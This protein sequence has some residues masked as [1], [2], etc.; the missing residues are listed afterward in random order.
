[1]SHNRGKGNPVRGTRGLQKMIS[2]SLFLFIPWPLGFRAFNFGLLRE[3]DRA[4]GSIFKQNKNKTKKKK[5]RRSKASS[6]SSSSFLLLF[7]GLS[8]SEVCVC[9]CVRRCGKEDWLR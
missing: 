2:H 8:E 6:S 4:K 9:V 5:K 7:L 1:M 3:R